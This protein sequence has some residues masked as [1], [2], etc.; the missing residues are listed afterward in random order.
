MH[1]WDYFYRSLS[2]WHWLKKEVIPAEA[3]EQRVMWLCIASTGVAR[4]ASTGI[5]VIASTGLT[6]IAFTGIVALGL[7]NKYN[8]NCITVFIFVYFIIHLFI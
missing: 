3:S 7:C 2:G 6:G 4:I 1:G 8:G 5:A